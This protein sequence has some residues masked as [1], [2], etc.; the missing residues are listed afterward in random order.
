M[1]KGESLFV[2]TMLCCITFWTIT[3]LIINFGSLSP[4]LLS[5]SQPP[6]KEGVTFGGLTNGIALCTRVDPCL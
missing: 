2:N 1:H 4:L 5:H 6:P 3:N